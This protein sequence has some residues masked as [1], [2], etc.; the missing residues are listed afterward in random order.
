MR[1]GCRAVPAAK[2]HSYPYDM[3]VNRKAHEIFARFFRPFFASII[4]GIVYDFWVKQGFSHKNYAL[5]VLFLLA[6]SNGLH[7]CQFFLF[8]IAGFSITIL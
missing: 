7:P 5:F 3:F 6:W 8:N 2:G 4:L 1:A